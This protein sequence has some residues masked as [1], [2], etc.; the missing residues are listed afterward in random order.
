MNCDEFTS[1]QNKLTRA[2]RR[3]FGRG[4]L[5]QCHILFDRRHILSDRLQVLFDR[6]QVLSDCRK[7]LFDS[8][9]VLF[10]RRQVDCFRI[11]RIHVHEAWI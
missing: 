10:D 5:D 8:R 1:M 9:Q 7:V 11:Q 6:R 2:Q 3:S 4:L